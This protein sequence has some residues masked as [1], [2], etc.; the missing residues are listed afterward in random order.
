MKQIPR[1]FVRVD[2]DGALYTTEMVTPGCEWVIEGEG[3]ATEKVDGVLCA[4]IEGELFREDDGGGWFEL[5]G[6]TELDRN[7][8]HAL[9]N[10][11]WVRDD[12]TCE[13]VGVH[14]KSNPYG[15]DDDFLERH[16]RIKHLNCPRDFAGI[17]EYLRTHDIEGIVWYRGNGEMC[18]VDR[19]D[20]GFDWPV[21]GDGNGAF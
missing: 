7:L 21:R 10:T 13:A 12:G 14:F 1:L 20:F 16:G 11:P 3:V 18:V 4:I 19:E 17:R 9:N 15:L 2:D 6:R 5:N 8:V